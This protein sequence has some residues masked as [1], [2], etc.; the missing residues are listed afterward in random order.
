MI[1]IQIKV[2][3]T[4]VEDVTREDG[5]LLVDLEAIVEL[6]ASVL[7]TPL[8]ILLG[9]TQEEGDGMTAETGNSGTRCPSLTT[10]WELSLAREEP[11]L[12]KLDRSVELL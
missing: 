7:S 4:T 12:T 8:L 3:T 9:G 5:L 6:E 11:R 1:D 2:V 10:W